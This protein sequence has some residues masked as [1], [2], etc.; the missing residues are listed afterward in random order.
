MRTQ[1]ELG[2]VRLYSS[3]IRSELI[4]CRQLYIRDANLG[5]LRQ[6]TGYA[7]SAVV[8]NE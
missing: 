6:G 3:F 2:I 8:T 7:R 5:W 1:L 4:F